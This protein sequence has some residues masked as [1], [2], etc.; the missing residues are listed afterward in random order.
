MVKNHFRSLEVQN[1]Y[2][3]HVL[4]SE[5]DIVELKVNERSVREGIKKLSEEQRA[6]MVMR[7]KL[8]MS[9]KEISEV[10]ECPEGTVKSRLFYATKELSKKLEKQEVKMD[11]NYQKRLL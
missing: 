2:T 3:Q 6:V 8:N 9:I 7:F 1:K 4:H 10:F 5:K 11:S